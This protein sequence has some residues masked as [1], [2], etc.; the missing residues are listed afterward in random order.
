VSRTARI[1][2]LTVAW[3]FASHAS[4]Q[5]I[6]FDEAIGFSESAPR[7]AG[8]ARALEQRQA[9]DARISDTTEASR[10]YLM[11]GL[12][13]LS[14]EDRGFEGQLQI[15]HSWNIA[16]L[17]DSQR[18]SARMER[19]ARA[20][21]GR[22]RA[23]AQRLIAAR[24][25]L[26]LREQEEH[27]RAVEETVALATRVLERTERAVRGGVATQAD[28]AE[29]R[30]YLAEANA[31]RLMAEGA[32]VDAQVE[33]GDAMGRADVETL[34][35]T[36]A[37]PR[38]S[39]PTPEEIET[40]LRDAEGA[41]P[42]VAARLRALAN[43]ARDAEL[44]SARGARID[45]DLMAY[46]ESPGGLLLFAQLGVQFPLADLAARDRSVLREETTLLEAQADQAVLDWQRQSHTVAHEVEHTRGVATLLEG[47][48]VP[49]FVTLVE[50]RERQLAAGETT[51]LI[52]LDATRRLV[53]AR[54]ALARANTERTWAEMRA[55]LLLSLPE[56]SAQ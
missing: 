31:A 50:A 17:A 2:G 7:V 55:W 16:G 41:P 12:R 15:G 36:G 13:A 6:S 40:T 49:S 20:A 28:V 1:V 21:E 32:I 38:P 46:R 30:A 9:G 5:S 14:E 24:A 43:D 35:T 52:V 25:W 56:E 39:L 48:L 37:L 54:V 22:F 10:V 42:V 23:L 33:L 44:S 34:S 51:V 47:E 27:L 8:E 26:S 29:A 53:D 4:A 11:P 3:F 45:A 18:R 19:D